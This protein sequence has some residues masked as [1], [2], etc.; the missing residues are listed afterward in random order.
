VTVVPPGPS[1]IARSTQCRNVE[2]RCSARRATRLAE[3][4]WHPR[5]ES[6]S[7]FPGRAADS[8]L[9][10]RAA[11]QAPAIYCG[12]RRMTANCRLSPRDPWFRY[13]EPPVPWQDKPPPAKGTHGTTTRVPLNASGPGTGTGERPRPRHLRANRGRGVG[14]RARGPECPCPNLRHAR[15]TVQLTREA[16]CFKTEPPRE[17]CP[18]ARGGKSHGCRGTFF[19]A[20][21]RSSLI[22]HS[23]RLVDTARRWPP[24]QGSFSYR[25]CFRWRAAGAAFD[26]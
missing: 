15:P 3:V 16:G 10:H 1:E 9:M 26:D 20:L 22:P 14:R 13:S 17:P 18:H 5:P 21:I 24:M 23:T 6:E 7:P 11:A 12:P 2:L 25:H 4:T 8:T 19:G